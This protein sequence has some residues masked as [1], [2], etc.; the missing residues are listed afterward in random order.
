MT[1]PDIAEI[2]A[3]D[4]DE[5][6][7]RLSGS[8]EDA[9]AF[10]GAAAA[11]GSAEAQTVFGQ[12]LLD[13]RGTPRDPVAALR[14]FVAAARQDH[15]QAINMVGRCFDLGWGTAVDKV[16]AAAWF[17][18]AAERGLDWGMY[19]YATALALGAGVEENRPAALRWLERAADLGNAKA[20]N[21]VGSFH[22]DGWV[23]P[24]DMA[25]AADCYARA[26]AGGDFRGQFNH[27]RMLAAA[28]RIDDALDWLSRAMAG[29]NPRFRAQVAA[30]LETSP[31]PR[32]HAAARDFA[33]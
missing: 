23:G 32:L 2:N 21:F 10:V 3:L 7:R 8:P 33:A 29:G 19:N 9:A 12:I 22:E 13:G 1:A 4:G 17:R 5:I 25:R 20:I 18:A 31:E 15:L 14:W 16:Q 24:R 27:A 6:V 11:A 26:A 28:G 30:W